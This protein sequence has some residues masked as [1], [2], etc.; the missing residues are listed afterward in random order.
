MKPYSPHRFNQQSRFVQDI[1]GNFI[2]R[3]YDRTLK[4]LVQLWD[5]CTRPSSS[6]TISIP[7]R[8]ERTLAANRSKTSLLSSKPLSSRGKLV[9]T[10][11]GSSRPSLKLN[12]T[13][14]VASN[15]TSKR[16]NDSS[17]LENNSGKIPTKTPL[18]DKIP[19]IYIVN[20]V[21]DANGDTSSTKQDQEQHW[22]RKRKKAK[23]QSSEFVDLDIATTDSE[24]FPVNEPSSI[25]PFTKLAEQVR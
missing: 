24:T 19:P 6:S 14:S 1:P 21:V 22:K 7:P 4:E 12:D 17:L 13:P 2:K 25:M 9:K 15:K 18:Q 23:D 20:E 11:N 8:P 16:N 10:R 5:F 3:P